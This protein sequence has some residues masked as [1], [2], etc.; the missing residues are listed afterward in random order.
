MGKNRIL[1]IPRIP[2]PLP[3]RRDPCS[4]ARTLTSKPRKPVPIPLGPL[5][6]FWQFSASC[7]AAFYVPTNAAS[8]R[9]SRKAFTLRFHRPHHRA[10][11]TDTHRLRCQPIRSKLRKPKTH[12]TNQNCH[13]PQIS[14]PNP[15][16][17]P[18]PKIPKPLEPPC[19]AMAGY[20]CPRQAALPSGVSARW[21][22]RGSAF[23]KLLRSIAGYRN[24]YIHIYVYRDGY[25]YI[26]TF[27]DI[28][29]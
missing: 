2:S 1:L 23:R 6:R 27:R 28:Q 29:E 9:E 21:L 20:L 12:Q 7:T 11:R 26:G 14:H 5:S 10:L 13:D 18:G 8:F 16:K 22:D 17:I 15:Q 19:H 4:T 24:L 25:E 3:Q